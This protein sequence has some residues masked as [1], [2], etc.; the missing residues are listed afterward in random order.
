ML[1]YKRLTVSPVKNN[2]N[3]RLNEMGVSCPL[4]LSLVLRTSSPNMMVRAYGGD[5]SLGSSASK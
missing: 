2:E 1:H 3:F 4:S 5:G